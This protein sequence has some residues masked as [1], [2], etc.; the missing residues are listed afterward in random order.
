MQNIMNSGQ[1]FARPQKLPLS[2]FFADPVGHDAGGFFKHLSAVFALLRKDLV[3][4]SLTDQGI[5]FPSDARVPEQLLNIPEPAAGFVQ[6]VFAVP[7]AVDTACHADFG[8]GA[9]QGSVTVVKGQGNL[10][11]R[12]AFSFLGSA[13]NDVFHFRPAQDPRTLFT[14]Y[15][16]YSV[17]DIAFPGPIGPDDAGN[18]LIEDDFRPVH[19][20]L[21]SVQLEFFKLHA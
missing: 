9:F 18:P 2:L 5:A 14:E 1:V 21:E 4:P 19:E 13:E 15:P 17:A 3:D 10:A 12:R 8:K 16:A 11:V 20:G 6:L 7:A